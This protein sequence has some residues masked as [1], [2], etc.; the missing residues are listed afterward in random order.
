[1]IGNGKQKTRRKIQDGL[2]MMYLKAAMVLD[3]SC[4]LNMAKII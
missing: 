2:N 3:L 4:Q 1:M